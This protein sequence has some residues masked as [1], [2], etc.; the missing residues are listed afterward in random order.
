LH[1]RY[2]RCWTFY[3]HY[4]ALLRVTF[5]LVTVWLLFTVIYLRWL[6]FYHV[7]LFPFGCWR[8]PVTPRS[9]AAPVVLVAVAGSAPTPLWA[10]GCRSVALFWCSAV[11]CGAFWRSVVIPV[12]AVTLL[13]FVILFQLG[14]LVV[15]PFGWIR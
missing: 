12:I 15:V 7:A 11:R 8:L 2:L 6:P 5:E 13:L 1:C 3:V 4:R 10:D 14:L 9:S